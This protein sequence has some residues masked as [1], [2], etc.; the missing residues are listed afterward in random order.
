MNFKPAAAPGTM[1]KETKGGNNRFGGMAFDDSDDEVV[2]QKKVVSQQKA[3]KVEEKKQAQA[4]RK[5]NVPNKKMQEGGFDMVTNEKSTRGQREDRPQTAGGRGGRGGERG[6]GGE[7]RGRGGEGRGRGGERGRGGQRPNTGFNKGAVDAEGNPIKQREPREDRPRGGKPK[8]GHEKDRQ[9]GSGRG[10]RPT[11]KKHWDKPRRPAAEP[12]EGEAP[13]EEEKKEEKKEEE[14][15]KKPT[16]TEEII[17]YSYEEIMAQKKGKG[18]KDARV[19]EGLKG[20]KIDAT[21][22]S[23]LK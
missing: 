22:Q 20:V 10:G 6:R 3:A 1:G 14:V 23:D 21:N 2:P 19:T 11:E 18:K 13:V 5:P 16:F 9:D 12:K 17:G 8:D 7:G 15:E 4:D